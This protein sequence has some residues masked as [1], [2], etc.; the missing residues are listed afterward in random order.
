MTNIGL[1]EQPQPPFLILILHSSV[2]EKRFGWETSR[3]FRTDSFKLPPFMLFLPKAEVRNFSPVPLVPA[4]RW[5]R[6][7][8]DT[9]FVRTE[10]KML[11]P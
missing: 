5:S 9:L 8:S 11:V 3:T 10:L 6:S 2:I 1:I 7:P 4:S